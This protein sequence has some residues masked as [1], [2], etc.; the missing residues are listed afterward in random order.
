MI[1]RPISFFDQDTCPIY[2][3]PQDKIFLIFMEYENIFN[4]KM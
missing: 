4:I 2:L 1:T 3:E